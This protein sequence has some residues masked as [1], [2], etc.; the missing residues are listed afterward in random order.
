MDDVGVSE[1]FKCSETRLTQR[2]SRLG[3]RLNRELNFRRPV[4][5]FKMS[6]DRTGLTIWRL[7]N[8]DEHERKGLADGMTAALAD[9]ADDGAQLQFYFSE[10][11]VRQRTEF[12]FRSANLRFAIKSAVPNADPLFF[13]LEWA[14]REPDGG[15]FVFPGKGAAH[16]HWQ[17]DGELR[18]SGLTAMAAPATHE[19]VDLIQDV[20]LTSA[21]QAVDVDLIAVAPNSNLLEPVVDQ[22]RADEPIGPLPWFHK[23]HLPARAMW[24]R[25]LCSMPNGAEPQQHEPS[26]TKE[27]DRWVI[28]AL[29][30]MRHEFREYSA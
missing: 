23:L 13:R 27:I 5:R 18:N 24:A 19:P 28:S 9:A 22:V 29:R 12:Q 17:F 7:E 8:I 10:H 14:A 15:V 1:P 4:L 21:A 25:E 11:W 30:Y 26:G 2:F 20:D 6:D 16:P 3:Q